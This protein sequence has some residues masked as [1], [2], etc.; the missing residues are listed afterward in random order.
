MSTVTVAV[1][2]AGADPEAGQLL[3]GVVDVTV[4]VGVLLPVSGLFTVTVNVMTA[5]C[6][7]ARSP[8]QVRMGLA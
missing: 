7:G 2:A 3:P 6:P 5:D 8:A 1:Q 4:S